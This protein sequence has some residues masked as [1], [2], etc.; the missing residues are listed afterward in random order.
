EIQS[1]NN[2]Q[3]HICDIPPK[4]LAQARAIARKKAKLD[5]LLHSHA[6]RPPISAI[7]IV[8]RHPPIRDPQ[9]PAFHRLSRFL[10]FSRANTI[11]V[12]HIQPRDPLDVPATLPLQSSLSAQPATRFD[13]VSL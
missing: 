8:P 6:T 9:Q 4:V 13:Q 10:H 5:H 7:L 12:R 11:P 2:H 1:I 3:I